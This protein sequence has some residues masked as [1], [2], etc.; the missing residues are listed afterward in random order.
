[1]R[2]RRSSQGER[3]GRRETIRVSEIAEYAYCSRAW[4]FKH[5]VKLPEPGSGAKGRLAAG[6]QAHR[7][8]GRSV[9]ASTRLRLVGLVLALCGL[10]LLGAY[11][12]LSIKY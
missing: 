3:G 11:L 7:R 2:P 6:T 4:W 9:A 1:V 8:H 12:V 10:A 5:V